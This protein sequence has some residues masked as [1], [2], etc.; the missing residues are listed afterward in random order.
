MN[1]VIVSQYVIAIYL[2]HEARHVLRL[3]VHLV[4]LLEALNMMRRSISHP[5]V[6]VDY[7]VGTQS[8]PC[9]SAY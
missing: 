7:R 6:K 5:T 3:E 4:F 1:V 8:V 2:G 9:R